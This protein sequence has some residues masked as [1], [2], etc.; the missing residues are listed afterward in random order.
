MTQRSCVR[1]S[2]ERAGF[3][4]VKESEEGSEHRRDVTML[5]STWEALCK[6]R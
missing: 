4:L 2:I 3:Y 6:G 5:A 1:G